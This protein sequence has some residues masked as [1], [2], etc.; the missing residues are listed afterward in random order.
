MHN[1]YSIHPECPDWRRLGGANEQEAAIRALGDAAQLDADSRPERWSR[2]FTRRQLLK[3]GLGVGVAALGSQLV[4]SRVSYAAPMATA[5]N[6]GRTLVVVFLRGGMD[7]LSVLVPADDQQLL[8]ARPDIGIRAGSLIQFD[9]SFGLHPALSGLK[10]MLDAGKIAAVPDIATPELSRS[11]FQAQDC[12]ERGGTMSSGNRGWLDRVLE[13]A[14]AGTT[15]RSLSVTSNLT[16][17]L[18]GTS[19][20]LVARDLEDLRIEADDALME[21]TRQAISQ[22]YTGIEHPFTVQAGIALDA[23]ATAAT[24]AAQDEAQRAGYPEGEFGQELQTLASLIKADVGVRVA[25]VDLGGWD[26]H[27]GIGN[28]DGGDMRDALQGLGDGIGAF[29]S[30]LGTKADST[31]VLIMSEFGRRFE[32]NGSGG[33][34]HG[35]GGLALAIGAG[36]RGGVYGV[37]NGLDEGALAFGDLPG[38]NDF[39][40]FL[41]EVVMNTVG[42][43]EGQLGSVFPDW[44]VTPAGLMTPV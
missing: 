24:F 15:F 36:V 3:G 37:W 16:R 31:T 9:R 14:G 6:A 2:G 20:A 44:K 40:N 25:T 19:N 33:T 23:D 18:A 43:S 28:V 4:T 38:N 11:H 22:L 27:T 42:L 34:D 8:A 32:Q 29:F 21:R 13:Q 1:P 10:P 30:D 26:M 41:G 12:L 5:G 35:H 39:R 17:S 7:G